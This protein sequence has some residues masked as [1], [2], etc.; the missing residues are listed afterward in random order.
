MTATQL[1]LVDAGAARD[2]RRPHGAEEARAHRGERGRR[3]PIA[4]RGGAAGGRRAARGMSH[5]GSP[6]Y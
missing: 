5:R 4:L 2:H 6:G 3:R 1:T